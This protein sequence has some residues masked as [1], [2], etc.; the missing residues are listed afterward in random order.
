MS[1]SHLLLVVEIGAAFR[2]ALCVI[3]KSTLLSDMYNAY[4]FR[5]SMLLLFLK[6][7]Y[8]I[9]KRRGASKIFSLNWEDN[10]R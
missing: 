8:F 10:S 3:L 7:F 1:M 4:I 6:F 2:A 9:L 5:I